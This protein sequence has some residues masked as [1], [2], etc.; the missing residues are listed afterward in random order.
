MQIGTPIA[1]TT[2]HILD[3]DM[4]P[5]DAGTLWIGGAGLSPGAPPVL[6]CIWRDFV[7]VDVP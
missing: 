2:V 5:A 3:D 1:N 4:Q 6:A 7:T